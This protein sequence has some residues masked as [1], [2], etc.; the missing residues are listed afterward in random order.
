MPSITGRLSPIL[1]VRD[2]AR[3]ADWYMEVLGMEAR[4]QFVDAEGAIGDVTLVEPS[5]GLE[6]GLID[7][8]ANPGDDFS[9]FRTG[10]DHLEFLVAE[11]ADLDARAEHFDELGVPHSGVKRPEYTRNAMLTLRDPDN[12]QLE[13]FWRSPEGPVG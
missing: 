2:L 12:I 13:L 7:H 9:E 1:T 5:S 4:R 10:L 11:L 3:S 8:D 6:I